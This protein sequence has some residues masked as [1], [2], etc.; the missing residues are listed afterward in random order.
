MLVVMQEG[1]YLYTWV[2]G[3]EGQRQR[4]RQ[5]GAPRKGQWGGLGKATEEV[6]GVMPSL[7]EKLRKQLVGVRGGG[8]S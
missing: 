3:G 4:Q 5:R 7:N 2:I 8:G 1:W 6:T